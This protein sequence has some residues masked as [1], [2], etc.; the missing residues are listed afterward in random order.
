MTTAHDTLSDI[1]RS[2]RLRGALFYDI[3]GAGAWAAE[4]PPASAIAAA[5]MPGAEHVMEYH[6]ITRGQAWAAVI[7]EQPVLVSA[8]D[9]VIFPHG[10]PHVLASAPDLRPPPA[11]VEWHVA[12]AGAA[13][14]I[15]VSLAGGGRMIGTAESAERASTVLACG[16]LGCTLRPF[17]SLVA[18][19]PRFMHLP[20]VDGEGWDIHAVRQAVRESQD[21]RPGG[22]AVLER[23]SEMMFADGVRRYIERMPHDATGWLAGLRNECVGGALAAMHADPGHPWSIE[24]LGARVGLSRSALHERFMR[25]VGVAPMQ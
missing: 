1:L 21:P 7:G 16:F 23:L 20:A 15:P 14:P 22:E 9:I 5:V 8:G 19:L 11:D 2:L 10:D 25:L 6:F 12:T 4:A 24:E 18:A 13:K 17:N 3:H